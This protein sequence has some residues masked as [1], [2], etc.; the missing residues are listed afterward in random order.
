MTFI[1]K[2]VKLYGYTVIRKMMKRH[3]RLEVIVTDLL[4][5]YPAEIKIIG[6]VGCQETYLWKNSGAEK[7]R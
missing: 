5:S 7:S 1:C 3:G 6:I 4:R 2:A